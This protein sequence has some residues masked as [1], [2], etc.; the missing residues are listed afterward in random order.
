MQQLAA[1]G[2][3]TTKDNW[4][5]RVDD[6][7]DR[8]TSVLR[9]PYSSGGTLREQINE[10]VK[11]LAM[12]KGLKIKIQ[13]QGGSKLAFHLTKS[14]PFPRDSCGRSTCPITC[15]DQGCGEQ[16]YQAHSNYA[17]LCS[18]C[19]PPD[20]IALEVARK[21]PRSLPTGRKDI[22]DGAVNGAVAVNVHGANSELSQVEGVSQHD[23]GLPDGVVVESHVNLVTRADDGDVAVQQG[24]GAEGVSTRLRSRTAR[25][26]NR[27]EDGGSER[28]EPGCGG[29]G[30]Q[31]AVA[32]TGAVP[33]EGGASL[34]HSDVAQSPPDGLAAS[35]AALGAGTEGV[36][37]RQGSGRT[38]KR[39]PPRQIY[40]GETSRGCHMRFVGHLS[41]YNECKGFMWEHTDKAHNGERGQDPARDFYMKLCKVDKDPIRR[42]VRES[43]RIKNGREREDEGGTAM[44]NDKSEWFGVKIVSVEFKQE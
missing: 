42:V 7:G 10:S 35:S 37:T 30:V 24:A 15:G 3:K 34:R 2:G 23:G 1:K 29:G 26:R 14:D 32:A 16:C 36:S 27:G 8:V 6:G 5:R 25:E 39:R 9:V 11:D 21:S 43:I 33:A 4:F 31:L 17:I 40:C 19:D 13:E 18:R 12:P 41:K 44:M 20:E 38:R 22:G 28:G